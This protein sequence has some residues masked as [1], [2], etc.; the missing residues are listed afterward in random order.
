MWDLAGGTRR[1]RAPSARD[2]DLDDL[3]SAELIQRFQTADGSGFVLLHDRYRPTVERIAG[4]RLGS[5]HEVEDVTQQV[6][7]KVLKA[8]DTWE[9]GRRSFRRWLIT[10]TK[11][12]AEDHWRST[13]HVD[14]AV[15]D[16]LD[17]RIDSR[18]DHA[19]AW[20]DTAA[21][22]DL[23][24][25]LAQAEQQVL[26]LL[27]CWALSAHEAGVALGRSEAA[28]WKLHSRSLA[29]LRARLGV[30]DAPGCEPT[31]GRSQEPGAPRVR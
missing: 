7:F 23:I 18:Q 30:S 3:I 27:Y 19:P 8:L 13:R 25:G 22:H 21:I 24:A 6:F 14:L 28:I 17:R 26:V 20:G 4:R 29:K 10:V 9:P 15:A 1:Q 11:T 12:T 31:G 5:T 2:D 16:Q